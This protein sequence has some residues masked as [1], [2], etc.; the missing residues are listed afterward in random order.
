M[1][2]KDATP[3]KIASFAAQMCFAVHSLIDFV[4][5]TGNN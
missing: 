1:V 2:P 3:E 5:N 4:M